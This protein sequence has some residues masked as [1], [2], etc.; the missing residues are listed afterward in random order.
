MTCPRQFQSTHP[1]GVRLGD[2]A[3]MAYRADI[4]IH[5]PQWGATLDTMDLYTNNQISIHAPQWGATPR[6]QLT[7]VPI[8][9]FNPRTPVG[10]DSALCSSC[11]ALLLFQ[12]THPSGVRRPHTRWCARCCYFNPRT[13]VGC[14]R[15]A[16]RSDS[17]RY[18][19]IH[20][21][22]WGATVERNP[23]ADNFDRFQS[24]HPS[25]V[26]QNLQWCTCRPVAISIHAPQW[27]ATRDRYGLW[28]AQ[29]AFQSTHPS[30][31]R[32]HRPPRP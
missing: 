19:S 24:T 16:V 17:D 13:P 14:D 2:G 22:Q 27:G 15:F 4:S 6:Y 31:V 7:A 1:S 10:C 29:Y 20:A 11:V 12:S 9:D 28:I 8:I 3:A 18:I 5:A 26:R 32:R 30:G 23:T 25:G 21:P